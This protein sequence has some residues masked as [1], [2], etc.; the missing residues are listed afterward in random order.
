[1]ERATMRDDLQ[2]STDNLTLRGG[3]APSSRT[4]SLWGG[5][6]WMFGVLLLAV[7]ILEIHLTP[8]DGYSLSFYGSLPAGALLSIWGA[9][10]TFGVGL[11][12]SSISGRLIR[13]AYLLG[14]T[15]VSLI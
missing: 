9:Y 13:C 3:F 14:M 4:G 6:G 8:I 10:F 1:M 2:P 7:A 5:L 11:V 12:V 15:L